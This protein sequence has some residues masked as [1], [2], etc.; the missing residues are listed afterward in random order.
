MKNLFKITAKDIEMMDK[1]EFS[2]YVHDLVCSYQL[3]STNPTPPEAFYYEGVRFDKDTPD[4]LW[5]WLDNQWSK[6]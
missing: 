6:Q 3:N 2:K 5:E 4:H 1:V